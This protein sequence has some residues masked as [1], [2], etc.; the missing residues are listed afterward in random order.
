VSSAEAG[1][2]DLMANDMTPH[3][4]LG[5]A[6]P[7]RLLE[8]RT[9]IHGIFEDRFGRVRR[10]ISGELHGRWQEP[11]L[12]VDESFMYDDGT[13]ETR[14]WQITRPIAGKF[15]AVCSDCVGTAEGECLPGLAR[16]RYKFRLRLKSN[17]VVVDFDDRILVLNSSVAI[18]RSTVSKWGIRLGE[19][20]L[21]LE[22]VGPASSPHSRAGSKALV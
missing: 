7:T 6:D 4:A 19:L 21:V 5:H 16:M 9:R 20:F 1:E 15:R 11:G 3:A 8:G 17:V 12:V 22:K 14:Q 2:R 18:N 13:C 10:R